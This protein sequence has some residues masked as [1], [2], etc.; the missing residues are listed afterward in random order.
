MCDVV[1]NKR[2]VRK[3]QM[4]RKIKEMMFDSFFGEEWEQELD[5]LQMWK[6]AEVAASYLKNNY[7]VSCFTE[8]EIQSI[9]KVSENLDQL[10]Y[11]SY[12]FFEGRRKLLNLLGKTITVKEN[13]LQEAELFFQYM[14]KELA[15]AIYEKLDDFE[16]AEWIFG[17]KA[18]LE[19]MAALVC[20]YVCVERRESAEKMQPVLEQIFLRKKP[21]KEVVER[22]LQN[23]ESFDSLLGNLWIDQADGYDKVCCMGE[24]APD[25]SML[26][27]RF[28][29]KTMQKQMPEQDYGVW[30]SALLS[31]NSSKDS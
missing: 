25:M 5:F 11:D 10:Q 26:G 8:E 31:V 6:N 21:D 22:L 14:E 30:E 13:I 24:N 28:V 27:K 15:L 29:K 20:L 4:I 2:L 19:V 3:R 23:V 9:L 12:E 1:L 7:L 16:D 17:Q 18:F